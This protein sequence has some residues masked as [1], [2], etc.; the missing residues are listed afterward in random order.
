MSAKRLFILCALLGACSA[1]AGELDPPGAPAPTMHSLEEIYD[2]AHEANKAVGG[3][4]A[5]LVFPEIFEASFVAENGGGGFDTV[6]N[7]VH[8]AR[9]QY[10]N[11]PPIVKSDDKGVENGTTVQ[12][13]LFNPDGSPVEAF[14]EDIANPHVVEMNTGD[15][16]KRISVGYLFTQGFGGNDTTFVLVLRIE[17]GSW[18]EDVAVQVWQVQGGA[19]DVPFY[20]QLLPTRVQEVPFVI[21]P[22]KDSGDKE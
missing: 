11:G 14:G 9:L 12:I 4:E 21:G 17:N 10:L 3:G 20:E 8:T 7:L 2:E 6:I 1:L 16:R 18:D 19:D 5:M 15:L 13:Y 22:I